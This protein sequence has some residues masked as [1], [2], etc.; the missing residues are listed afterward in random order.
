M[1]AHF[2]R[3]LAGFL[4][5]LMVFS[6]MI[7][8]RTALLANAEDGITVLFADGTVSGNTISYG[9]G[10]ETVVVTVSGGDVTD[11]AVTV[12]FGDLGSVTFTLSDNFDPDTMEVKVT[13]VGEDDFST[14]LTVNGLVTSLANKTNDGGLPSSL[15]LAVVQA[16]AG[17]MAPGEEGGTWEFDLQIGDR[18]YYGLQ[19]DHSYQIEKMEDASQITVLRQKKGDGE[20]VDSIASL[21]ALGL[22]GK[23]MSTVCYDAEG[24]SALEVYTIAKG[25]NFITVNLQSHYRDSFGVTQIEDF[26]VTNITFYVEGYAGVVVEQQGAEPDMFSNL[27]L[28]NQVDLSQTTKEDPQTV[29]QYFANDTFTVGGVDDPGAVRQVELAEDINPAAV[30]IDG[31]TVR[32]HSNF[33]DEVTFKVTMQ[34]GTVGY[35]QVQRL[36]LTI[37]ADGFGQGSRNYI[38]H[39]T[40]NGY[41]WSGTEYADKANIVGTFYYDSAKTYQDYHIIATLTYADGRVETKEVAGIGETYCVD[42]SLKG[43]DYILYSG[44]KEDAPVKV[45]ATVVNTN[46]ITGT[47]FGGACF[48]NGA[49]VAFDVEQ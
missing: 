14:T 18:E 35:V 28:S 32:F 12:P 36:G 46:A 7:C 37:Q 20:W 5:V 29:L 25:E 21:E 17:G 27:I 39:G 13:G 48:G 15:N 33:Y 26:Y 3:K 19:G 38:Y 44:T 11:S 40:Q 42:R 34:D 22:S 2:Q 6:V 9:V 10:E 23:S 30:T 47:A 16:D 24:R 41:D 49:G 45:S 31:N 43:G 1:K 4:A 8:D